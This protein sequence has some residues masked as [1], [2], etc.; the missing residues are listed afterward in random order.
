M[1]G[2]KFGYDQ[3]RIQYIIEEIKEVI[4]KN[5]Q[6]RERR[7]LWEDEYYYEYPEDIIEEFKKGIEHLKVAY[8]YAQRIDWL[9]CGDDGEDSFRSRLKSDLEELK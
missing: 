9:L 7:D 4:E 8:I 2:G 6:K 1:S 3:R 5:G